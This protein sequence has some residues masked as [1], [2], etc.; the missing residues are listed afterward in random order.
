MIFALAGIILILYEAVRGV[1]YPSW[2]YPAAI[3]VMLGALGAAWLFRDSVTSGPQDRG[4]TERTT[5]QRPSALS[6]TN[7]QLIVFSALLS[8]YGMRNVLG[9]YK[10]SGHLGPQDAPDILVAGGALSAFLTA[11]SLAVSRVLRADG[12]QRH[13]RGQGAQ[14][15]HEGRAAEIRAEFEG[16]AAE[17][18]AEFEG[19]ALVIMAE[20]VRRRADAEYLRAEK[21]IEPLPVQD[22]DSSGL[23][24][25]GPAPGPNG[26]SPGSARTALPPG[27][28][29]AETP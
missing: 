3:T 10:T 17:T 1:S 29:E 6:W 18:K 23:P 12:A 21:G 7:V 19:R 14:A 16:R 5:G 13:A 8:W 15:E 28:G 11:I 22:P 2:V 24:A 20:A 25:I 26:A 27:S 9:I 4:T